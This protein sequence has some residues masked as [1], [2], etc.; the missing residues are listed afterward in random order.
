VVDDVLLTFEGIKMKRFYIYTKGSSKFMS[1][2]YAL[3]HDKNY[4]R[5]SV[6]SLNMR[7]IV[8]SIRKDRAFYKI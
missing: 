4:E 7:D 6:F 5:D 1:R 8:E 3:F 2:N